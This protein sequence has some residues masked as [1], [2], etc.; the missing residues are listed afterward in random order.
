[1]PKVDFHG[2]IPAA[3]QRVLAGR[4]L[5]DSAQIEGFLFPKLQ[6]LKDPF[7]IKNMDVAVQRLADAFV[8][9]EK[10]AIYA[11][12]DLDGTSGLA[13]MSTA[14]K[15]L[16]YENIVP[17]QPA[18]L[19][20]GY[21][22]HPEAVDV[23][24]QESVS[25]I[26]TVDVGIT[27]IEACV[28]AQEFKIDVIITDHHLPGGQLP[29]CLAVVN[30]NQAGDES[31]LGYLSGAGVAFYLLRGLKRELV[32]RGVAAAEKFDLKNVLEFFTIA[33]LTDMVPLID[34]NRVLVKHGLLKL[35]QTEKPGLKALKAAVGLDGRNL[36]SQ[37]V[38][39]RLAP[40]LN[41]LSR[42]GSDILPVDI[43]L[44]EDGQKAQQLIH[45]V[46]ENNQMRVQLQGAAETEIQNFI[47]SAGE[48]NFLFMVS[49]QFHRGLVGLLATKLSNDSQRP[50]F[51]GSLD[52]ETGQVVGS[53]RRP[54]GFDGCLVEILT[55][56]KDH[57]KRFG[58][59][60]QAAGFE[61]SY[62]QL[63]SIKAAM[64][65]YF[66]AQQFKESIREQVYDTEL[67]FSEISP[68]L[69]KWLEFL[70]PFGVQFQSP[71]FCFKKIRL[72]GI[73]ELRGGHLRL[74]CVNHDGTG[75]QEGLLFSPTRY[76][77]DLLTE[78]SMTYDVLGELQWNYYNGQQNMQLLIKD[79][80]VSLWQ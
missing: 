78:R 29:G 19:A 36:T 5:L 61:F 11:D 22:F 27:A 71:L 14:L 24:A 73:K 51:V 13:L 55:S 79:L 31:K 23:L 74:T 34:D 50:S 68:Q 69:M 40:K 8:K 48:Q 28:R 58:G 47:A 42:M 12:F 1:M 64:Q 77:R 49:P 33:T 66:T 20:E 53:A 56:A 59:H 62:S 63:D 21:G 3:I 37:D 75:V 70:G 7:L 76:Q 2:P 38:A 16:G 46:L 52:P 80:R 35:S 72:Q 32:Q 6:N 4:N 9:K 54:P 25:L 15:D 26:V 41:A 30:P 65:N 18:R 10:V 17:Y 39:I 45:Q 67:E 57:L 44:C 60:S 43:L